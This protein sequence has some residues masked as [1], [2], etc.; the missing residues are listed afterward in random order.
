MN[1]HV[2]LVRKWLA[3]PES[4]S[5]AELDANR[6]DAFA[7]GVKRCFRHAS[8]AADAVAAGTVAADAVD[9][10]R[11]AAVAADAVDVTLS[12]A[13]DYDSRSAKKALQRYDEL[14]KQGE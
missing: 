9:A 11:A 1:P 7:D 12:A 14:I 2:E 3:D 13:C 8:V 5:Q 4:V 6:D 10:F